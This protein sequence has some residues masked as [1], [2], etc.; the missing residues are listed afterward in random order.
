MQ[1]K[2]TKISLM[3]ITALTLA[4]NANAKIWR[5]NNNGNNPI[6]AIVSDFPS[7]T[8]LQQ[9]HD[10][11]LVLSGDTIHVEQSPTTYGNCIFTKRLIVIGAGYFLNS[12]PNTQVNNSYGSTV[13]VL[14]F[15]NVG[16]AGSQ[17]WGLTA[18]NVFAGQNNLTI[19]RSYFPNAIIYVGNNTPTAIDN[20]TI[21]QNKI[22]MQFAA[23]TPGITV[24]TG[25][26]GVVTNANIYSNIITANPSYIGTGINLP[27]NVSGIIKNNIV[28]SNTPI[29]V[30]N[31]YVVNNLFNGGMTFNNCNIEYNISTSAITSAAGGG[32]T[33]GSGN[34]TKTWAQI[35]FLGGASPDGTYQ[36]GAGSV[37][38]GAGNSGVDCGAFAGDYPYKLSGIAPI[39][40]IYALTIA[41]I[42]AGASTISVTV[43]AKG[44]N[45]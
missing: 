38:T 30:A 1:I 4:F 41:P 32:N 5:L 39:P 27:S 12:N 15:N 26:I 22:E 43:S 3:A 17:I 6:P 8:T 33:F 16:C 9:V 44:N 36:L 14:T 24:A 21:K 37:A 20:V 11:A 34:Q 42:A 18:G 40:N 13:G 7:S 28:Y 2:I 10:N 29:N 35:A 23:G 45:F 25:T 19:A 31:F